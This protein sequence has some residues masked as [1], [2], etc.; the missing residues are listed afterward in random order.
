MVER[1]AEEQPLIVRAREETRSRRVPDDGV[2]A[3]RVH[4]CQRGILAS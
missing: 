4:L 1:V 3:A 2:D